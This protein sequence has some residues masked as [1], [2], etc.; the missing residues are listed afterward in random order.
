MVWKMHRRKARESYAPQFETLGVISSLARTCLV[1]L[2]SH[3]AYFTFITPVSFAVL[4]TVFSFLDCSRQYHR[5]SLARRCHVPFVSSLFSSNFGV[6]Y[7]LASRL[8]FSFGFFCCRALNRKQKRVREGAVFVCFHRISV[9]STCIIHTPTKPLLFFALRLAAWPLPPCHVQN[10]VNTV[11]RLVL[12]CQLAALQ[13]AICPIFSLHPFY[14]NK[15]EIPVLTGKMAT[16][17]LEGGACLDHRVC[18]IKASAHTHFQKYQ[19]QTEPTPPHLL[20]SYLL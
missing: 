2:V 13:N 11:F 16:L 6:T 5:L 14:N 7:L 9:V 18:K 3:Q 4:R 15:T 19:V 1:S 10:L 8:L 20:S 12:G 17:H